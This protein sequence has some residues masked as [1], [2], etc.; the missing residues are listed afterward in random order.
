[1]AFFK[2]TCRRRKTHCRAICK[3]QQKNIDSGRL[4]SSR[5]CGGMQTALCNVKKS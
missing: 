3:I 5:S 1:M 2:W 4:E